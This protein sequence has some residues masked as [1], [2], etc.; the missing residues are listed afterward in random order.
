M[1][2]SSPNLIDTQRKSAHSNREGTRSNLK[3]RNSNDFKEPGAQS[4]PYRLDNNPVIT[5]HQLN[6][7]S[8]ISE[9]CFDEDKK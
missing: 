8:D 4:S 6:K 9:I 3:S 1:G 7:M 2:K 5:W